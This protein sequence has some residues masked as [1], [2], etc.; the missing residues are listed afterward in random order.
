MT[1]NSCDELPDGLLEEHGN[2]TLAVD[3]MYINKNLFMMTISRATH[4]RTAEMIKNEKTTIMTLL[5]QIINTYHARG[6]KVL[7]ILADGQF[8]STRKHIEAMGIMLNMT[9]R[10]EHVSEIE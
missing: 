6:F 9:G 1:I 3:I 10:D 8:E 5:K 7:H 2:V 4:F